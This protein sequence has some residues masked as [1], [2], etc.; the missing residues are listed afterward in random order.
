MYDMKFYKQLHNS[1]KITENSLKSHEISLKAMK[2]GQVSLQ[3]KD[4][5]LDHEIP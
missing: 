4:S 2:Y 5:V 1:V 3:I